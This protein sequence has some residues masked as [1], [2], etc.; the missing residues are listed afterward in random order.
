M[1]RL[2]NAP[3]RC[4]HVDMVRAVATRERIDDRID[5]RRRCTDRAGFAGAFDAE[6]IGF[7][8]YIWV[9]NAIDGTS[10]A[11]GVA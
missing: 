9:A 3:G 5:H 1:Q 10:F 6:R 2:P 11:R 8:R 4:R 7:R